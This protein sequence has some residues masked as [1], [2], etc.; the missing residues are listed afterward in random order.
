MSASRGQGEAQMLSQQLW[1]LWLD[2]PDALAQEMLDEGMSQRSIYDFLGAR[3]TLTRLVD[4]CP[5]YA[6]G[7]NQR[8]FASYLAQDFEAALA[9]LNVALEI[10]PNH[11]AALSGKGLTLLGL[12]R[13]EEAQEALRAA[14]KMNPWLQER[15]LLTE[16]MGTDL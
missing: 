15:A 14:V 3:E 13:D 11:I 5:D 2:A 7:Y 12:G 6:E 16:P 1:E 10:M 4:Y 9:D 8:A